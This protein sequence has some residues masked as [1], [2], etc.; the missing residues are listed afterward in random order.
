MTADAVTAIQTAL[1]ASIATKADSATT[2][3]SLQSLFSASP[4]GDINAMAS[5]YNAIGDGVANDTAAINA[6]LAAAN[7]QGGGTV[8]L[9]PGKFLVSSEIEIP[10]NTTLECRTRVS[11]PYDPSVTPPVARIIAAASWAPSA[12]TGIVRFRSKTAGGWSQQNFYSGLRN[13]MIDGSL[14]SNANLNGIYMVG[15][16][17]DTHFDDVLIYKA[18]HNAITAASQAESGIGP[19]YPWHARWNRVTAYYSGFRGFQVI[20]FTDSVYRDCMAFGNSDNGWIF[21]NT[22]NTLLIGCKSEWN[23]GSG[24]VVTGSGTGMAFVGCATDQNNSRGFYLNAVTDTDGGGI[25]ITGGKTHADGHD[26]TSPSI[27]INACSVPINIV[28]MNVQA[29]VHTATTCPV[30]GLKATANTAPVIVD[31]CTLGGSTKGFSNGGTNTSLTLASSTEYIGNA[32]SAISVPFQQR[33]I[34]AADQT[35]TASTTFVDDND[36]KTP[37]LPANSVWEVE[38]LLAYDDSTAGD[39][40]FQF[41]SP[42][43]TTFMWNAMGGGTGASTSPVNMGSSIAS[44][45]SVY[46]MGGIGAGTQVPVVI[47]GILTIGSTAG[48]F[49]LQWAQNTSDAATL[50]V[51]TGSYMKLVR[52]S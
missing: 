16:V 20:N 15:P 8:H 35:V 24:F 19:T 5:P 30:N 34:K 3:A 9:A 41:A 29:G 17:F 40:K 46:S 49:K 32:G 44:V 50:S 4:Q 39:F 21:T 51:R 28:G 25:S 7:T 10:P 2:A 48:V 42:S 1:E 37:S 36:I 38:G 26:G 22:G 27:E 43:G 52:I 23:G 31:G 47:R 11:L 18:P 13:V 33:Y 6:A 12:A 14:N 45:S